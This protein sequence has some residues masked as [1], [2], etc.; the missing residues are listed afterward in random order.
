VGKKGENLKGRKRATQTKL[1]EEKMSKKIG[2]IKGSNRIRGRRDHPKNAP[3][4]LD[5]PKKN[6]NEI[7][8]RK[9]SIGKKVLK[10]AGKRD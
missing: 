2:N 4:I 3:S 8:I 7:R 9:G 5:F 1:E 6:I 10:A